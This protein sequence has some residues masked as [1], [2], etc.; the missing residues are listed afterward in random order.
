MVLAS[1][2]WIGPAL[3]NWATGA[4]WEDTSAH[5]TGTVPGA[6]DTAVFGGVYGTD[7]SCVVT[8]AVSVSS[9]DMQDDYTA[10]LFVSPYGGS[11]TAGSITQYG[12]LSVG[13]TVSG[14]SFTVNGMLAILVLSR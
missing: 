7:T 6:A 1:Y 12:T 5:T 14:G 2:A 9:L 13:G 11:L 4:D 8:G 3:G 10:T